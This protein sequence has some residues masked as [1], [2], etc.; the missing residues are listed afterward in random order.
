V[1]SIPCGSAFC[2]AFVRGRWTFLF[3][4]I[5]GFCP[6]QQILSQSEQQV[7]RF[8]IIVR[9]EQG[10]PV[11]NAAVEIS[12]AYSLSKA[13]HVGTL[14]NAGTYVVDL[15]SKI[16]S[17]PLRLTVAVEN[18]V[19]Y[20]EA[21]FW[22]QRRIEVKLEGFVVAKTP[23][24][25]V[26]ES[27][28]EA[29]PVSLSVHPV[30][31]EICQPVRVNWTIR[32][33]KEAQNARIRYKLTQPATAEIRLAEQLPAWTDWTPLAPGSIA[34]KDLVFPGVYTFSVEYSVASGEVQTA[35]TQFHLIW[36]EPLILAAHAGI[37]WSAVEATPNPA[38]RDT[39]LAEE[40]AKASQRWRSIARLRIE[41]L[42]LGSPAEELVE[43]VQSVLP[44]AQTDSLLLAESILAVEV[45]PDSY[46]LLLRGSQIYE[47]ARRGARN[48]IPAFRDPEENRAITMAAI[49]SYASKFFAERASGEAPVAQYQRQAADT[50]N[51]IA[52]PL[53]IAEKAS[54]VSLHEEN[55]PAAVPVQRVEEVPAE[56]GELEPGV[57]SGGI[58]TVSM[59]NEFGKNGIQFVTGF[60]M[61][62]PQLELG[63]TAGPI[64]VEAYFIYQLLDWEKNQKLW[65]KPTSG[66]FLA[67]VNVFPFFGDSFLSWRFKPFLGGGYGRMNERN[68]TEIPVVAGDPT[69]GYWQ[70]AD[71]HLGVRMYVLGG[72]AIEAWGGAVLWKSDKHSM[73]AQ[74]PGTGIE[75]NFSK[76]S[77]NVT[78]G[79]AW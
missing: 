14:Q 1:N 53:P 57:E 71:A 65:N 42:K 7:V 22:E 17:S 34:Y 45:P 6:A 56:H 21:R 43:R 15:P 78:I 61:I 32:R 27:T 69:K 23:P 66:G 3:V 60:S 67:G 72:L 12:P 49:T 37:D 74:K 38:A 47:L 36:K 63:T 40:F 50:P 33:V 73:L 48:L 5:G 9:D 76:V 18:K 20:N 26:K 54:A 44:E 39:V 19:L 52:V 29:P 64:D 70:W 62:G 31:A 24:H 2:N 68:G 35:A 16:A 46:S 13:R 8:A 75:E 58:G 30:S 28:T 79:Y 41:S 51:S 77:G 4:I 25:P 55:R 59:E 11:D 10:V